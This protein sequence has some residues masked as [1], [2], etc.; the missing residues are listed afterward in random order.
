MKPCLVD[1]ADILRRHGSKATPGRLMLLRVLWKEQK[2]IAV[3][4]L[5]KKVGRALNEVTLYRA[6]ESLALAGV[7]ERVD[8]RHG[9]THYELKVLRNHHHH[10]VCTGC[11]TTEDAA[12]DAESFAKQ[13]AKT[14]STFKTVSAHAVEFFGTCNACAK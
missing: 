4:E 2:P 12:C 3:A 5:K 9:H 6:L 10:I 7:V 1:F 11:G 13:V 8:F 14:S